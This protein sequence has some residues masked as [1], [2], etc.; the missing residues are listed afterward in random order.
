MKSAVFFL[1]IALI[2]VICTWQLKLIKICMHKQ[3]KNLGTYIDSFLILYYKITR[4]LAS[5]ILILSR[6]GIELVWTGLVWFE[7]SPNNLKFFLFQLDTTDMF[8][9][10]T[11]GPFPTRVQM[12]KEKKNI[13][14]I[15]MPYCYTYALSSWLQKCLIK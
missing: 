1:L 15:T 10:V 11:C 6:A 5:K 7:N 9:I 12:A 2:M 13:L 3:K 14:K 4:G 8:Y